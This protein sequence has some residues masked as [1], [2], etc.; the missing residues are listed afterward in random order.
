MV[1]IRKHFKVHSTLRVLN[2]CRTSF[3]GMA[4]IS[5]LKKI[6]FRAQSNSLVNLD[7]DALA[8]RGVRIGIEET[9]LL[10]GVPMSYCK[11]VIMRTLAQIG[12]RDLYN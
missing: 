8:K 9:D 11:S 7:V 4:R 10:L 3:S 2:D 1:V 12:T 5:Y 6:W